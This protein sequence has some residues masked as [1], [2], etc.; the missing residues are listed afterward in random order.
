MC[1]VIVGE[2][3]APVGVDDVVVAFVIDDASIGRYGV[4]VPGVLGFVVRQAGKHDGSLVHAAFDQF[5]H[6]PFGLTPLRLAVRQRLEGHRSTELDGVDLVAPFV[7]QVLQGVG[8][9]TAV[10][11]GVDADGAELVR[12]V[13]RDDDVLL[14]GVVDPVQV[15]PEYVD[16]VRRTGRVDDELARVAG[17]Y[18]R[19]RRS[20]ARLLLSRIRRTKLS[21]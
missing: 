16:Q 14:F 8:D 9:G 15:H 18:P 13:E 3:R 10:V 21:P 17:A 6:E 2:E 1:V 7:P 5:G 11:A 12:G 20:S 4:G 19:S